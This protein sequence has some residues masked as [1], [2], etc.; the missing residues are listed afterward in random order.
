MGYGAEGGFILQLPKAKGKEAVAEVNNYNGAMDIRC[1]LAAGGPEDGTGKEC[2]G[3]PA[4]AQ[5]SSA[6]VTSCLEGVQEM[7][8]EEIGGLY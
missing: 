2:H 4:R 8:G 6:K 1:N 5:D 3:K 7:Q